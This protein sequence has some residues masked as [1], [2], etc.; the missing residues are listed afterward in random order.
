M[1]QPFFALSALSNCSRTLLSGRTWRSEKYIS[2]CNRGNQVQLGPHDLWQFI[3]WPRYLEELDTNYGKHE[4]QKERDQYDVTDGFNGHDH[5]LN[6]MLEWREEYL[7]FTQ[8]HCY[9]CGARKTDPRRVLHPPGQVGGQAG[10]QACA[11]NRTAPRPRLHVV[12]PWTVVPRL[13]QTWT[14]VGMSPT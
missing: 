6:D 2:H 4:L 13:R 1:N 7:C 10:G 14:A 5:A 8:H 11:Y 9:Y 12:L 3:T